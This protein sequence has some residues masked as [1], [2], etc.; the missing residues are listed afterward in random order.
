[1]IILLLQNLIGQIPAIALL[2]TRVQRRRDMSH[3]ANLIRDRVGKYRETTPTGHSVHIHRLLGL[4]RNS[5]RTCIIIIVI[6]ALRLNSRLLI[7][8]QA[9]PMRTMPLPNLSRLPTTHM[10]PLGSATNKDVPRLYVQM[11]QIERMH[12]GQT[13]A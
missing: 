5:Q 10:L 8:H 7:Q 1:M 4:I 3:I 11:D 13:L 2:N 6:E 12:V 9:I